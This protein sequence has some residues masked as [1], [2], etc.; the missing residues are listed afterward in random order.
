MGWAL[1]LVMAL[2]FAGVAEIA[3]RLVL[4]PGDFLLAKLVPDPVRGHRIQ[5]GST[6]HDK[7]GFRNDKVLT[8][9]QV[10]AFGDSMT[11]GVMA[12]AAL[13]WPRQLGQ[14]IDAPVY[15]L[16]LGGYGPLQYLDLARTYGGQIPSK[17]WVVGVYLGNDMIDAYNL[18]HDNDTWKTY[19][20]SERRS[21]ELSAFDVV[22]AA[23]APTKRFEAARHWLAQNSM[24]YSVVRA[25]VAARLGADKDAIPASPLT[26]DLRWRW[27]DRRDPALDTVFQPLSTLTALDLSLPQVAE[28]FQITQRALVEI[29]AEAERNQAKL[30]VMLIPTKERVYCERIKRSA[31]VMPA[32]YVKLCDAEPALARK[33]ADFAQKEDI[34]LT[35][36]AEP[37]SQE[38]LKGERLYLPNIDGHFVGQ[39]NAVVASAM[40][41][42]LGGRGD[43]PKVSQR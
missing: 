39:G 38:I 34:P 33:L 13:S 22:N 15:N 42:Y 10:L 32:A 3:L 1:L 23:A 30:V 41:A 26:D 14:K 4:N 40:A 28:G 36:V 43:A 7:L 8:S 20:L 12:P 6:G 2:G 9:A 24:L 31:A 11:Y 29:K 21:S 19:R 27:Q 5:G 16:G 35:D 25:T 17:V 37:L 18:A